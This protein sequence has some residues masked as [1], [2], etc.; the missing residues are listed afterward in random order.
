MRFWNHYSQQ[1]Y[2]M[3]VHLYDSHFT[4][5]KKKIIL[6]SLFSGEYCLWRVVAISKMCFE[7]YKKNNFKKVTKVKRANK[8]FVRFQFSNF[9]DTANEILEKKFTI[10][11]FWKK[12]DENEETYLITKGEKDKGEFFYLN[13]PIEGGYFLNQTVSFEFGKKE[14]LFLKYMSKQKIKWKKIKLIPEKS[15]E[16]LKIEEDKKLEEE[17]K[18]AVEKSLK[19]V[20]DRKLV[21]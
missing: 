17:Y 15:E 21:G 9:N 3:Y 11:D 8:K 2:D 19:S 10:D 18:E 12:I 16:D 20:E 14:E 1:F 5:E 4:I 6:R 7:Q 13:I